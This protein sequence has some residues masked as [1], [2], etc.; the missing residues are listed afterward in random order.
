[1]SKLVPSPV[2][3]KALVVEEMGW[4]SVRVFFEVVESGSHWSHGVFS[5]QWKGGPHLG[6]TL[7]KNVGWASG[8][9][10]LKPHIGEVYANQ[11]QR[12]GRFHK[13]S[14]FNRPE[15]CSVKLLII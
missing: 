14:Y 11:T 1:M 15:K 3:E 7:F 8:G 4:W 12:K 5:G 9:E 2:G 6:F 10:S 13:I